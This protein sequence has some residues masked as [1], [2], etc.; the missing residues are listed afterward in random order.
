[1]LILRRLDA[2]LFPGEEAHRIMLA[3]GANYAAATVHGGRIDT[4]L[5]SCF[6]HFG[7]MHIGFN[8]VALKNVGPAVE[9]AVGSGRFA[10]LYVA[11]GIAGSI[12]SAAWGYC[13]SIYA[14]GHPESPLA[15]AWASGLER[16]SAGASGAICGLIG[17]ILVVG[18]R[19]DGWRN[20]LTAAMARWLGMVA[21]FGYFL[22]ADNAAHLGGAAAGALIAVVWKRKP[23]SVPGRNLRLAMTA[24]LTVLA[25]LRAGYVAMTDP[26]AVLMTKERV[27]N[28]RTLAKDG[29]CGE[30]K[31]AI[32][33]A[34]RLRPDAK[35]A[36]ERAIFP[37]Q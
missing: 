13:K 34:E 21:L 2:L 1:M 26:D 11:S 20:P 16:L 33:A 31:T 3:F 12:A 29:R 27:A 6:L 8:M 37:C 35:S 10:V 25:F 19:R 23:E 14:H 30:A 22:G 15:D 32:A 4:L 17:A 24:V 28:A 7:I 36:L 18:V 5:T 9:R